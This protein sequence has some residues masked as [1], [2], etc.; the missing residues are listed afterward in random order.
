MCCATKTA[1]SSESKLVDAR[2]SRFIKPMPLK[3]R[4]RVFRLLCLACCLA[5]VIARAEQPEVDADAMSAKGNEFDKK[6]QAKDALEQ[7][8]PAYK[9]G[10][11]RRRGEEKRRASISQ[12]NWRCL[13][14]KKMTRR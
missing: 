13:T 7:Y 4:V 3:C 10:F 9:A 2:V 5:S 14:K 6:L 8:L 12:K 1:T 11:M